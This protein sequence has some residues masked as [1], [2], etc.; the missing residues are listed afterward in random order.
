[1]LVL[2]FRLRKKERNEPRTSNGNNFFLNY[3]VII[4][5]ERIIADRPDNNDDKMKS[6]QSRRAEPAAVANFRLAAAN[7]ARQEQLA[8]GFQSENSMFES[9]FEPA[10]GINGE[11]IMTTHCER[12][13]DSFCLFC[14][15]IQTNPHAGV[16]GR[17][18]SRR[19]N[20]PVLSF[21]PFP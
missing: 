4:T 2:G 7:R 15:R 19:G 8:R 9:S 10:N 1:M 5:V 14:L 20:F 11:P 16:T 3:T 6:I 17:G 18:N 21:F 13:A 12:N